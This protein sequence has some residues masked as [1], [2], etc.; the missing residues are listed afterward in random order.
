MP[1]DEEKFA[2]GVAKMGELLGDSVGKSGSV[3]PPAFVKHTVGH[4]FGDVWQGEE[5][6]L[7]ERSLLTCTVLVALGRENEQRIHFAGAR[8]IG[9]A[10]EKLEGAITHVAH[11]AGW[12]VAV[13]AFG[14]L[15]EVWPAE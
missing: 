5:M 9:I 12:P 11:Y 3:L 15:Q 1:T 6:S 2:K 13:S 14:I 8:N 10:R 7:Q 4:L